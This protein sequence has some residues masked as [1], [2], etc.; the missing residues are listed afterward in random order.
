MTDRSF[1]T[2][3]E[4]ADRYRGVISVR[5]LNNWR[6]LKQGPA[7]LKIGKAIL[8]PLDSLIEWESKHMSIK[9]RR[10]KI[11]ERNLETNTRL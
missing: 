4:V 9:S 2:T 5:T 8:Y 6:S 1:L 3:E 11:N 7:F 10:G